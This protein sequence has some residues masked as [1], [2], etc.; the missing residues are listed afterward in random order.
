MHFKEYIQSNLRKDL[1]LFLISRTGEEDFFDLEN[2][3]V[4]FGA[5]GSVFDD[6]VL[7]VCKELN[8]KGWK[9]KLSFGDTGLFI[10]STENP[11]PNCW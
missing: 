10:Y 8:N 3:R 6:I 9:T 11:P 1:Q 4:N 7:A 5:K 2:A